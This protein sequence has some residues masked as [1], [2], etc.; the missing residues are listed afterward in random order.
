M[1]KSEQFAKEEINFYKKILSEHEKEI[2]LMKAHQL[3]NE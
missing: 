1:K 3:L 2:S